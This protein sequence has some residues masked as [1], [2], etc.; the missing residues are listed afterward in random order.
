M[1]AFDALAAFAARAGDLYLSS[2]FPNAAQIV[3]FQKFIYESKQSGHANAKGSSRFTRGRRD[4][5][6][7]AA[8]GD[9]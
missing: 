3:S 2:S 5:F 1:D 4:S 7:A 8:H 9:D 6:A